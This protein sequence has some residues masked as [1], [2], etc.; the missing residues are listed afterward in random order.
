MNNNDNTLT[1]SNVS[2][3]ALAACGAFL[4]ANLTI[5]FTLGDVYPFT[6]APMFRDAPRSYEN[7]RVFASDGT[8]LADNSTRRVDPVNAPDPFRL[9]RYYDGNPV[10]YGVGVRPPP[11]LD[12]FGVIHSE[13][14]ILVH[15]QTILNQQTKWDAIE[16]EREIV[17]AVDAWKVGVEQTNR[18][19]LTRTAEPAK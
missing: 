8:K 3:L 16:I 13:A 6:V 1:K 14:E 9:R 11:T 12:D 5:P 10:G 18:W 15:F 2:P 19:H 17:G 4:L 7:F